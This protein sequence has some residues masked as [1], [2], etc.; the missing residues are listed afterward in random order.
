MN[1]QPAPP[2][3]A[4]R[5]WVEAD[6]SLTQRLRHQFGEVMVQLLHQADAPATDY[7]QTATGHDMGWVR[8]VI[9]RACATDQPLLW[10]RTFIPGLDTTNPWFPLSQIGE[11]PLGEVLFGLSDVQKGA[12]RSGQFSGLENF[13]GTP[14]WGRWRPW[15]RQGRI[16]ILTEVFL[17]HE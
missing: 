6:D 8:T 17:F 12:I 14:R 10:A 1:W 4:L 16:M 15:F 5:D 3:P 2:P 11:K 13:G 9:L 7:E